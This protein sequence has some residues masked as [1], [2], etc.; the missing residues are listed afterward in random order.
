MT[1][2]AAVPVVVLGQAAPAVD[3]QTSQP[4]DPGFLPQAPKSSG[5]PA[6][7][8]GGG[9]TFSLLA[10]ALFVGWL[11]VKHYGHKLTT[12]VVGICIGV[13][14]AGGFVGA[15]AWALIRVFVTVVTSVGNA[16]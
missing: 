4:P 11:V 6:G 9:I 16:V 10:I 5:L 1:H 13:L 12:L 3:A 7:A 14:G 8:I 15:L 2:F